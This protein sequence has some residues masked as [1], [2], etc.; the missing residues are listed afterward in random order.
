VGDHPKAYNDR[1]TQLAIDFNKSERSGDAFEFTAQG[2]ALRLS[3]SEMKMLLFVVA[4]R[5]IHII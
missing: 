5:L 2:K 3:S 1:R 4:T